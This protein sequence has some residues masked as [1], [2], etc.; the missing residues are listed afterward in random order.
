[1]GMGRLAGMCPG[2]RVNATQT[3][4]EGVANGLTDS[5]GCVTR[6]GARG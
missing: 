1:M 2:G 5:N 6:S 3:R 4:S